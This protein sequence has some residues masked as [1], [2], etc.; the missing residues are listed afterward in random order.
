MEIDIDNKRMQPLSRLEVGKTHFSLRRG[1]VVYQDDKMEIRSYE[2]KTNGLYKEKSKTITVSY[3]ENGKRLD[4]GVIFVDTGNITNFTGILFAII[5]AKVYE[6]GKMAVYPDIITS[7]RCSVSEDIRKV[8]T[9]C[10]RLFRFG[11]EKC[12]E[13]EKNTKQSKGIKNLFG[14]IRNTNSK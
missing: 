6:N 12:Q 1:K 8:C 9:Q 13:A 2:H 11:E 14:L 7:A 4:K 10:V 5:N 3:K